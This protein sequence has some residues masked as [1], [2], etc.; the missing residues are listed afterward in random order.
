MFL[1]F[2]FHRSFFTSVIFDSVMVPRGVMSR[3]LSP[4]RVAFVT[5]RVANVSVVVMK[6]S[7]SLCVTV[8]SFVPVSGSVNCSSSFFGA[9]SR[10]YVVAKCFPFVFVRVMVGCLIIV[11]SLDVYV[12]VFVPCLIVFFGMFI[13][14]SCSQSGVWLL[15]TFPLSVMVSSFIVVWLQPVMYV[16]VPVI[17]ESYSV[18]VSANVF[19]FLS[20]A[21]S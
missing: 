20:G 14:D 16:S 1:E 9:L 13:F 3:V 6:Y 7:F 15:R 18:G 5:S 21:V 4:V 2:F 8:N 17:V 19:V 12:I 11:L 10:V